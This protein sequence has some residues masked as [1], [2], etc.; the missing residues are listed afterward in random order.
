[1]NE[2]VERYLKVLQ[3]K[4]RT[5]K[6]QNKKP[7]K[8]KNKKKMFNFVRNAF[9]AATAAANTADGN[10]NGGGGGAADP[11][12]ST[13]DTAMPAADAFD[14]EPAVAA[15]AA[16]ADGR[17]DAERAA[18]DE[19]A[20]I[21]ARPNMTHYALL[22]VSPTATTQEIKKAY[23]KMAVLMA[24][25]K[26]KVSG[27]STETATGIMASINMAYA[28]LRD[29]GKRAEYDEALKDRDD[30]GGD[31]DDFG[32][33]RTQAARSYLPSGIAAGDFL[34]QM[35]PDFAAQFASRRQHAVPDMVR[36][37]VP[38]EAV[39]KIE[40]LAA[41]ALGV[42]RL[43][44]VPATPPA[45][46]TCQRTFVTT[47]DYTQHTQS[48]HS[49]SSAFAERVAEIAA[50][51]DA[52][53]PT[54]LLEPDP[55]QPTT[56]A[57]DGAA[58]DF[59]TLPAKAWSV[60]PDDL[61]QQ[62]PR[63]DI[64]RKLSGSPA[65][66][67]GD[68]FPPTAAEETAE[69]SLGDT[70][71]HVTL[72]SADGHMSDGP[73][74]T[75]LQADV[76][77]FVRGSTLP[78][79]AA[80]VVPTSERAVGT[81]IAV[82]NPSA[83]PVRA[84]LGTVIPTRN[85][86]AP[87]EWRTATLLSR[88]ASCSQSLAFSRKHHCRGCGAVV[89]ANC[90][91]QRVPFP[92]LGF[93][94]Q[95]HKACN[96]C[97]TTL[98]ADWACG[99][100]KRVMCSEAAS[101][102]DRIKAANML[103]NAYGKSSQAYWRRCLSVLRAASPP[104]LLWPIMQWADQISNV[105]KQAMQFAH[106]ALARFGDA[107]TAFSFIDRALSA[108]TRSARRSAKVA[109]CSLDE[110]FVRAAAVQTREKYDQLCVMVALF[111]GRRA[112]GCD[113]ARALIRAAS[114][115][116]LQ[117]SWD[118]YLA[119]AA[120]C[121]LGQRW[122]TVLF[123]LAASRGNF[124]FAAWCLMHAGETRPLPWLRLAAEV[125]LAPAGV[126]G[127]RTTAA[128]ASHEFAVLCLHK[129]ARLHKQETTRAI[130]WVA[131]GASLSRQP[132][133]STANVVLH[134]TMLL[135][136]AFM[137]AL[138][139]SLD[140]TPSADPIADDVKIACDTGGAEGLWGK[141]GRC[142]FATE[143][144]SLA[145][146]AFRVSS[147]RFNDNA[148]WDTLAS[149]SFRRK[150]FHRAAVFRVAQMHS[151]RFRA[152]EAN[153][154][155][156]LELALCLRQL[157]CFCASATIIALL[158]RNRDGSASAARKA[159]V[160]HYAE[161]VAMAKLFDAMGEPVDVTIGAFE[162]A[163]A[164]Q[165]TKP[166]VM[167]RLH[168]LRSSRAAAKVAEAQRAAGALLQMAHYDVAF[169]D[170]LLRKFHSRDEVAIEAFC[171]EF[172]NRTKSWHDSVPVF[173][174]ITLA[175]GLAARDFLRG[176][177]LQASE[178]AQNAVILSRGAPT[179]LRTAA[180]MLSDP[181]A[182]LGSLLQIRASL[183]R[184]LASGT[185]KPLVSSDWL[186]GAE[187]PVD[188]F[189]TEPSI[190]QKEF[191]AQLR[192][193][194]KFEI[195]VEREAAKPGKDKKREAAFLTVDAL[196]LGRGRLCRVQTFLRAAQ[197][198]ELS[199]RDQTSARE[200]FVSHQLAHT[201]VDIAVHFAGTLPLLDRVQSLSMGLAIRYR[202]FDFRPI[203]AEDTTLDRAAAE[204]R[205]L[206]R[207]ARLVPV[208][209]I[210]NQR[211]YD[212]VLGG[213][214]RGQLSRFQLEHL[215]EQHCRM[216][217]GLATSDEWSMQW[218]EGVNAGW[219]SRNPVQD[220]QDSDGDFSDAEEELADDGTGDVSVQS[221]DAAQRQRERRRRK[222]HAERR[223]RRQQRAERRSARDL[224]FWQTARFDAIGLALRDALPSSVSDIWA[225]TSRLVSVTIDCM[226]CLLLLER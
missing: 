79:A 220:D 83:T 69:S 80:G 3:G 12:P 98:T 143:T 187:R 21:Q 39:A 129:A 201:C 135:L 162:A 36:K 23:R 200:I 64:L 47:E 105:Q 123:P 183:K 168:C 63:A 81:H 43:A 192:P 9:N 188:G 174:R 117:T 40:R 202:C 215:G 148:F 177:A 208:A 126:I 181:L 114:A 211:V 217:G 44:S 110:A 48:A 205:T 82:H 34:R 84:Y 213:Q 35:V 179:I 10:G 178:H 52:A 160:Q 71:M 207:L 165:A 94:S 97:A 38:A 161:L 66:R 13:F 46:A 154:R 62:L 216:L 31:D 157:G 166:E 24:P 139:P 18:W 113:V 186:I 60:V 138:Q 56:I 118:L 133:S 116:T 145:V 132:K 89:C 122:A 137:H 136:C 55:S 59:V 17:T 194:R 159:S 29:A 107:A 180:A 99:A 193:L 172:E 226:R 8:S 214:L 45:C 42:T 19:A 7:P 147:K 76:T 190:W 144:V 112:P 171:S 152:K 75:A 199:G 128:V 153:Q 198:F 87:P 6:K 218:L 142:L 225:E 78:L 92:S 15:A 222:W 196:P 95:R 49:G 102:S 164:I 68:L 100:W 169:C 51:T 61:L 58:E 74:P 91:T 93:I 146:Y 131:V 27:L 25:D 206:V 26:V 72:T 111:M 209:C 210:A 16:A 134:P 22:Q 191:R 155:G 173:M 115:N 224:A 203:V 103:R 197:L 53:H 85:I 184:S 125:M 73:S 167:Q 20:R 170:I 104:Q 41:E 149:R 204:L 109:Y 176:H 119:P 4:A 50:A 108:R 219:I 2:P 195:G 150:D 67:W 151:T 70:W 33:P 121:H 101:T 127:T 221:Y 14:A 57:C 32:V 37:A 88:C 182:R 175:M 5:H 189:T 140:S 30:D 124:Q 156:P 86:S 158:L 90:S 141:I 185:F 120:K 28:V 54:D 11:Q 223:K 163:A 106:D 130:D 77:S 212:A 65:V 1:M 96:R